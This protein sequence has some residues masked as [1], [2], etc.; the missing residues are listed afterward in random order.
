M[1]IGYSPRGCYAPPRLAETTGMATSHASRTLLLARTAV[2]TQAV[3]VGAGFWAARSNPLLTSSPIHRRTRAR[4]GANPGI[5]TVFMTV[6]GLG[7]IL[8]AA[9]IAPSLRTRPWALV[10]VAWTLLCAEVLIL[11]ATLELSVLRAPSN[12]CANTHRASVR[13]RSSPRLAPRRWALGGGA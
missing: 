7:L 4:R 3:F 5:F 2:F 6:W 12:L 13:P 8:L 11:D 1:P 9:A 10:A